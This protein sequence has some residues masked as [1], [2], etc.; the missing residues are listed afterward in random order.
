MKS[1]TLKTTAKKQNLSPR[2]PKTGFTSEVK[3]TEL[4]TKKRRH[5]VVSRGEIDDLGLMLPAI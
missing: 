5:T 1:N 4:K 3:T 2:S